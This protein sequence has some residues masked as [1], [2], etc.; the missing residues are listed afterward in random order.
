M[1]TLSSITGQVGT[2]YVPVNS[3]EPDGEKVKLTYRRNRVTANFE[4]EI[5]EL[6]R[7]KQS[8]EVTSVDVEATYILF[9]R[10]FVTW[11]L[12]DEEGGPVIPLKMEE[13]RSREFPIE[14]MML[15]LNALDE[16]NKPDPPTEQS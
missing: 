5:N 11:D 9:T 6:T 7:K 2:L 8:G 4:S 3:E 13:L 1:A 12:K 14:W 15:A 10:T 16:A